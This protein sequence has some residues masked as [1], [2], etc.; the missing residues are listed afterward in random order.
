MEALSC[1]RLGLLIAG[2]RFDEGR[3]FAAELRVVA[4]GR[5][6][7]RTL[8]RGVALSMVLEWR[9]GE[10]A[11]AAGHLEAFLRLFAETPYMRPLIR[12]REAR[13][14]VVTEFLESA[15]GSPYR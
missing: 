15:A 14:A 10:P 9:A 6:L 7:R 3:I 11:A 2:G 8:M 13:A 4:D 5:G 1:A 12:E